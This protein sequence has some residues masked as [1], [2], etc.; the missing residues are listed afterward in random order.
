MALLTD[1]AVTDIAG[2]QAYDS[3]ILDTARIEGI[4][5]DK[6]IEVAQR[7]V[8]L[9]LSVF[10]LRMGEEGLLSFNGQ[11]ELGKVVVT[12]GLERWH[13]LE[14][15][16]AVYGDAYNS[17]LNDRYLGRWKE[18][19][20]LAEQ[21]AEMVR[22]VGVG[23]VR[24][25][26]PRPDAPSVIPGGTSGVDAT[27]AI[28]TVWRSANGPSS[29]ASPAWLYSAAGGAE[30]TVDAGD[31][32]VN[33]AGWDVYIGVDGGVALKQNSGVIPVGVLW[34][35]PAQGPISGLPAGPG[36]TPDYYVRRGRVL[37]RG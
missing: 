8:E 32:P 21:T 13:A 23:I 4:D 29:A 37:R 12:A 25:P 28:R 3:S 24:D 33:A 18:Y 15:L 2:L 7:K 27:Y 9:E 20:R 11:P 22:E 35:V 17:Q 10:L 1:G 14:T 16:A 26:L 30:P 19:V 34:T 31:A 36:Q 5:L 6:K